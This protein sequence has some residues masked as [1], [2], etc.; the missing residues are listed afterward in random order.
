MKINFLNLDTPLV[1]APMDDVTDIPFRRICKQLGADVV[2]TEFTSC[3][4]LIRG[5]PKS[6][7]R[8]RIH[9]E[10]HPVGIQLFGS[11]VESM[12]EAVDIASRLRPDFIDINC[13]CWARNH[14][15]RGEGAALLKDLPL[16]ERIVT[17]V[18]KTSPVPVTVKTRL[19][20]DQNSIVILDVAHIVEQAGAQALTIHCRTRNQAYK[21]NA[22]WQWLKKVKETISIPV[23]GNG[24]V[25]TGDDARRMFDLGC[26]G[27]M[28]GRE[29]I[30]NPWI[31]KT[32]RH[33]LITGEEAAA[34]SP[35]QRFEICLQHLQLAEQY[36]GPRWGTVHLRKHFI[37]YIRGFPEAAHIRSTLFKI[38]DLGILRDKLLAYQESYQKQADHL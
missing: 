18:V 37:G 38:S 27:V 25:K 13:G 32:A 19:G 29:A 5:I 14:A 20:W 10:E 15:Q 16:L 33:Y 34:P 17:A 28:I 6:V 26:D 8:I 31:F 11:R 4:A 12:M 3:E 36:K 2:V 30:I 1:L 21:G 24:D 22:D 23:I 7:A 9:E 35:E